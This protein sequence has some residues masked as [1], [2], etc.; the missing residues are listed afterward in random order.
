MSFKK[1]GK[2]Q[3]NLEIVKNT[4]FSKFKEHY[5]LPPYDRFLRMDLKQLFKDLGGKVESRKKVK[6]DDNIRETD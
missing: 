1:V 6:E 5:S 3:F 4:T 2:V